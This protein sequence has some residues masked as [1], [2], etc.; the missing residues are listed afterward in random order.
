MDNIDIPNYADDNTSYTRGNSLEEVSE[1]LD[2]ASKKRA[3][4]ERFK[5]FSDNQMKVNPH[6]FN[7]FMWFKQWS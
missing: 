3:P 2:N 6:K 4:R 5:W 7:F 1:K